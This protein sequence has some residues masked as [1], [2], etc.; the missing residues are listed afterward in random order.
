MALPSLHKT[1]QGGTTPGDTDLVNQ[2]IVM[3]DPS[4]T[5][6]TIKEALVNMDQNPWTVIGSSDSTASGMDAVDR[7]VT[8]ASVVYRPAS[9]GDMS[10]IV[11]QN[12]AIGTTFQM[13]IS[14][15]D[16]LAGDPGRE[17]IN[18]AF[19]VTGYGAANGGT[20]GDTGTSPTSNGAATFSLDASNWHGAEGGADT[21]K[22]LSVIMSTDGE[23]TRFILSQKSTG[24]PVAG[25]GV[26]VPRLPSGQW[27]TPAVAYLFKS[28]AASSLSCFSWEIVQDTETFSARVKDQSGVNFETLL[29]FVGPMSNGSEMVDENQI[30]INPF[31]HGGHLIFD[32][33]TAGYDWGTLFDCYWVS[34]AVSG[35]HAADLDTF[36]AT[37]ERAFVCVGDVVWGWLDDG[38]TDLSYT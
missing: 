6:F 23:V 14:L 26:E 24:I 5:L 12:D 9:L 25:F 31:F 30:G 18:I 33:Q 28:T 21:D 15:E 36:P 38:A 22:V 35:A 27:D 1:Y 29:R 8:S 17:N 37:G 20:D 7:W 3:G 32:G 34:R 19:S 4:T 16:S 11:L 13:L 10:W 2:T